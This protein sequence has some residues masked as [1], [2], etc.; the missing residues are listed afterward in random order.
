MVDE[1]FQVGNSAKQRSG[2]NRRKTFLQR[3]SWWRSHRDHGSLGQSEVHGKE[4]RVRQHAPW[5]LNTRGSV[6]WKWTMLWREYELRQGITNTKSGKGR[7]WFSS[8]QLNSTSKTAAQLSALKRVSPS[9][10][11]S[12]G[13]G[14]GLVHPQAVFWKHPLRLQKWCC[15]SVILTSLVLNPKK[16]SIK[17]GINCMGLTLD[18]VE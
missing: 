13:G 17:H 18:Q 9:C 2:G 3:E 14:E 8:K 11:P 16:W 12:L 4:T 1:T 10:L 6:G 15:F 7:A 5:A